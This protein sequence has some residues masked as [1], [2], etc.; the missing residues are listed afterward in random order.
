MAG[1]LNHD[2]EIDLVLTDTRNHFVEILQYRPDSG[3][4]HAL[5]FRVFEQKTFRNDEEA[6]DSE[7]REALIADVTGDGLPDL[8]LLIHDRLLLYPQ[9]EGPTD[10]Q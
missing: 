10:P 8:L 3:L 1:D 4:K 6:G 2:G 5:Y 7:P 9:D